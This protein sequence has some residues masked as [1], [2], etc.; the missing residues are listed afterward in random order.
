MAVM[1]AAASLAADCAA[2][3]V[4]AGYPR[5]FHTEANRIVDQNGAVQLFHG[6]AV[7]DVLWIYERNDAGIGFFD[8]RLFRTA[9]DWKANILRLSISP[10]LFR[11]HGPEE[12]L[13][14]L[15]ASVA[16]ARR[17]GLYLI[18]NFHT[19]GFPPDSR[20]KSLVD[21][22]YG[23]LYRTDDAEIEAFWRLISKRYRN[24]PAIAFYELINEPVRIM[25]DGS[26]DY[27]GDAAAWT[28]WRDY[29]EHLVDII[30]RNDPAKT[31]IV[32][33]LE[34]AY[35]LSHAVEI[36]VRRPNIVYA[37][38]PYAGANWKRSWNEAFLQT[39]RSVPV[40]ATEF[41]WGDAHPEA[42]DQGG[43][44]YRQT[45]FAAFDAAGISWTAWS[46]S[47]TFPPSLLATPDF[48]AVTDYG[49]VVRAN[50]RRLAK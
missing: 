17:Y 49:G 30:R 47:H 16:F 39:A 2:Q 28:L 22:R 43:G 46:M 18:V 10:A 20:Y 5:T 26:F 48:S 34:F 27:S 13:K 25:A 37:T 29:A 44:P 32:G 21:W 31:V 19:I 1:F 50:L 33:G 23:E 6:V 7:P 4:S 14:A 42:S 15:D 24:E 9:A 40:F 36:P 41:G 3:A 45:I 38:H 12:T 35:D 8:E 11:K